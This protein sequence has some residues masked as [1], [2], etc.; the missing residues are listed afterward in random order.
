LTLA[1]KSY[2]YILANLITQN[3]FN[4]VISKIGKLTELNKDQVL[5]EFVN[6]VWTDL[7]Q[8][9]PNIQIVDVNLANKFI[10]EYSKSIFEKNLS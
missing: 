1:S 9:N 10:K 3:R 6:D 8:L 7:Y 5:E 2:Q 4:S